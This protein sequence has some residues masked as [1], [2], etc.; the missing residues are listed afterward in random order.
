MDIG[1]R[2]VMAT[3]VCRGHVVVM[4]IAKNGSAHLESSRG[5]SPASPKT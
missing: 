2:V 4:R 5:A 1:V 3:V